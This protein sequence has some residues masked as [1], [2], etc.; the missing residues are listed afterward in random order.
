MFV[1][2][3]EKEKSNVMSFSCRGRSKQYFELQKE[4]RIF[5]STWKYMKNIS[6]VGFVYHFQTCIEYSSLYLL[7]PDIWINANNLNK[8]YS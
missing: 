5:K 1:S 7:I 8:Q 3:F 2:S 6:R 4:Q